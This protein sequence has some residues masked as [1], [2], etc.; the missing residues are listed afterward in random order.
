[1]E[2]YWLP[3]K[4]YHS[5]IKILLTTLSVCIYPVEIK[6]EITVLNC[7]IDRKRAAVNGFG[8]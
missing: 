4:N 8:E 7:I 5:A 1:L 2:K 3:Q 6:K